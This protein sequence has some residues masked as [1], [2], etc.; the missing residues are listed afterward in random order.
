MLKKYF[1][2]VR[3]LS[4]SGSESSTANQAPHIDACWLEDRLL[5]SATALPIEMIEGDFDSSGF[6]VSQA[7]VDAIMNCIN[8]QLAG[9]DQAATDAVVALDANASDL[10]S[11]LLASD[12]STTGSTGS[13]STDAQLFT[14]SSQDNASATSS[15][16]RLE[17][18]FVDSSLDNLQDLLDQLQATYNSDDTTL[19]VVLIDRQTS[20]VEQITNFFAANDHEYSSIHLVTHG[21]SGQF[22]VGSDWLNVETL[23]SYSEQIATWQSSLTA[24]ADLLV[25]ACQVAST[26]DG[27]QLGME[28]AELLSVDVAMSTDATVRSC[29]VVIGISNFKRE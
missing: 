16:A 7:E 23:G 5:Y 20:G 29:A 18:A 9:V 1:A 28:L 12:L 26:D 21:S 22:Q 24:D 25:Y 14:I 11:T 17:V 10:S 15:A 13:P 8:E 6:E 3:S 4:L 27:Q 19:E 2:W